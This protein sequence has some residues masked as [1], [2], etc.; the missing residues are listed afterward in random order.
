M[1][2]SLKDLQDG[3][4]LIVIFSKKFSTLEQT[5]YIEGQDMEPYKK[6]FVP[7]YSTKLNL[8]NINNPVKNR[9][10]SSDKG[11]VSKEKFVAPICGKIILP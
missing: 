1:R 11:E 5:N 6:F 8:N 9:S 2:V 10:S 3:L 4:I 7:F